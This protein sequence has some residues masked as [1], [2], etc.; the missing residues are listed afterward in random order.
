MTKKMGRKL[1]AGAG[2]MAMAAGVAVT[3][4]AGAAS[5]APDSATWTDGNTKFVT[6]I[7]DTNPGPW[8]MIKVSVK[9]ERTSTPVEYV[10]QVKYLHNPCL[11]Y[12]PGSA[13]VNG[14]AAGNVEAKPDF[15]KVTGSWAV[16]PLIGTTRTFEF[17]FTVLPGCERGVELKPS[18]MHYGGTLGSGTYNDEGPFIT[19]KEGG[20]PTKPIFPG[21][22]N[23][24]GPG[25]LGSLGPLGSLF[26]S[27]GG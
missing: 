6:T 22:P 16:E 8:E 23:P 20:A 19:V 4:G 21:L 14:S 11:E 5:A 25:G 18:G 10:Q 24:G 2:A 12:V 1:V 7:D 13:L 17:R 15:T 26:G 3:M 27:L 9:F